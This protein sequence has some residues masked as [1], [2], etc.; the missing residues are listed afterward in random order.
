MG[1]KLGMWISSLLAGR[2]GLRDQTLVCTIWNSY[3]KELSSVWCVC[4][5]GLG[6][7]WFHSR[8]VSGVG[9]EEWST[10]G[11]GAADFIFR[12]KFITLLPC[13]LL[14]DN[15]TF[16]IMWFLKVLLATLIMVVMKTEMSIFYNNKIKGNEDLMLVILNCTLLH[17]QNDDWTVSY[18]YLMV[19]CKNIYL[20][21]FQCKA[22]C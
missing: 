21:I 12:N 4:W 15:N 17:D 1:P 13:G 18:P 9:C 11:T 6:W 10:V 5:G 2:S 22:W 7:G 3:W 20:R 16:L 8:L 19:C 14:V